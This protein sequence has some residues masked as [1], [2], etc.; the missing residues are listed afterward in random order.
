[1]LRLIR[2]YV[3]MWGWGGGVCIGMK[4]EVTLS[5][6]LNPPSMSFLLCKMG[7]VMVL[8]Q[9]LSQARVSKSILAI[10]WHVGAVQWERE[11][12]RK[13]GRDRGRG[14]GAGAQAIGRFCS[15]GREHASPTDTCLLPL[16]SP[17][18]LM[19]CTA[20]SRLQTQD[21]QRKVSMTKHTPLSKSTHFC[22]CSGV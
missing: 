7:M 13:G 15:H 21:N 11:R 18:L 2:G 12:E 10:A 16:P 22:F 9:G 1:M 4:S 14:K 20:F 8:L 19:L 5:S 17:P 6:F 3:C